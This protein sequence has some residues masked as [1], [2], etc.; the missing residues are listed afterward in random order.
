MVTAPDALANAM[1]YLTKNPIDRL[2]F[3]SGA[4]RVFSIFIPQ[5]P[6]PTLKILAK[7]VIS[8]LNRGRPRSLALTGTVLLEKKIIT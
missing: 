7:R 2:A 6:F 1:I 4:K 3:F 8:Y 5:Y